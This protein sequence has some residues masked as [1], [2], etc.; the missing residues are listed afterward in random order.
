MKTLPRF[1]AAFAAFCLVTAAVWAADA[2]GTWKW[3]TQ[4]RGG[5]GGGGT[6]RESTLTL[7]MKDGKLTGKLSTPG[8]DGATNATEI[9]N[10]AVKVDVV[11]FT[12]EREFNGNKFVSKYSGKL[13]G[14]TITGEIEAPGRDGATS[15]R[16]W[17][18]KRSK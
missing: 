17:V 9:T 7:A 14:D 18:A 16:E 6:P 10:G 12:V 15:K 4:G 8:R 11:S 13:A 3:T 2:S 1:V 5:G